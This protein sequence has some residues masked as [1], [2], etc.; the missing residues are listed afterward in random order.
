MN[1]KRCPW[2]GKIIDKKKD[3]ITWND[4]VNSAVPRRLHIANCA[5]CR[6]KYGQIPLRSYVLKIS[7]IIVFLLVL[8]FV[9]QSGVLF[10]IAFTPALLYALMPYS[11]LDDKGKLQQMNTDLLCEFTVID[12]YGKLKPD[13]LYFL[14][15]SFDDF[16]PFILA[17]PIQ[18]SRVS[19]K[20]NTVSGEFLYM[21]EKN[22][23]F[24]NKDSCRLYDTSMNL[25]A[26]IRF[27]V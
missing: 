20:D 22:Y 17:S 19:K 3:T 5:H 12:K 27:I 23:D 9:L 6:N 10:V 11:K 16:E 15:E 18:I 8:A 21:H 1:T 13:E 14:D 26:N 7:L 2:C 25:V 24:I 4:V